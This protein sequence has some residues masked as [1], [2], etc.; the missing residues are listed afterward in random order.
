MTRARAYSPKSRLRPLPPTY[1]V[2]HPSLMVAGDLRATCTDSGIL[3]VSPVHGCLRASAGLWQ[4]P[5]WAD[6]LGS[7][8]KAGS[9]IQPPRLVTALSCPASCVQ[10]LRIRFNPQ[11]SSVPEVLWLQSAHGLIPKASVTAASIYFG[12]IW[13]GFFFF[14]KCQ[15][16]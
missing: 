12:C 2:L 10:W 15:C 8:A 5:S 11:D 7:C 6:S 3:E 1:R 4:R 16:M 14:F 13:L 9:R